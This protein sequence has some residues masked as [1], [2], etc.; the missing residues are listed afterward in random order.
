MTESSSSSAWKSYFWPNSQVLKNLPGLRSAAALSQFE[1]DASTLRA[2]TLEPNTV[3]PPFSLRHLRAIHKHLFQ[4][5][6]EWAGE[7]RH[8]NI[9]KGGSQFARAERIESYGTLLSA[10]LAGEDHL[11]G[12]P[13]NT[14]VERL[15]YHY[16][17]WNALHPFREGNGRATRV[18]I[19]QL[20]IQAG[21]EFDLTRLHDISAQ[22]WSAAAAASFNGRMEPLKGIFEQVVRPAA[23][24]AFEHLN[25]VA[26]QIKHPELTPVYQ[27]LDTL[28]VE[29]LSR[30]GVAQDQAQVTL[31]KVTKVV[32]EGLESGKRII[33]ADVGTPA[34]ARVVAGPVV[35]TPRL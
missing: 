23:A 6:Y 16:S 12:L 3:R 31:K 11:R 25:P 34:A 26:A 24:F 17:E 8:V 21:Y 20:C 27:K 9:S 32:L 30:Y 29:L 7:L 19:G 4:D 33:P 14:F 1:H 13:K 15:A 35:K 22:Q 5:V 2:T 10:K 18:F 28:K